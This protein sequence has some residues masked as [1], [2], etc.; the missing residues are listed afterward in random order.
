M[1]AST[2]YV[3]WIQ[4]RGKAAEN[5]GLLKVNNDLN[6]EFETTTRYEAFDVFVTAESDPNATLPSGSEVLRATVQ[7]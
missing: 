1:P 3:V 2:S 5:Q 4:A 7:P 6:G